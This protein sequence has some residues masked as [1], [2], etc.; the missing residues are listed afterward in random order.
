MQACEVVL[1]D[2]AIEDLRAIRAYVCRMSR[3][4]QV[5]DA[6]LKKMRTR[7]RPLDYTAEAQPRFFYADGSDSGYRFVPVERHVAFFAI[8]GDQVR[9]KRILHQRMDSGFWIGR[10]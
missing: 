3:S 9:I 7:L 6:Y 10:M 2:D 4:R 5:A 8:E 1:L